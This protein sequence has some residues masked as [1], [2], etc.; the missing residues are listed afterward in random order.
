M[1]VESRELNQSLLSTI[2]T[3]A[4]NFDTTVDGM[5]KLKTAGVSDSV[6]QAMRDVQN[7]AQAVAT[8]APNI[9]SPTGPSAA[10]RYIC[11][12]NNSWYL[13]LRFDN[14]FL[15]K[16]R[17]EINGS[18]DVSGDMVTLRFTT[19]QT[20]NLTLQGERLIDRAG[21]LARTGRLP[22]PAGSAWVKPAEPEPTSASAQVAN[23]SVR[24]RHSGFGLPQTLLGG[25]LGVDYS[26]PC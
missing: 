26:A 23:F 12:L 22:D 15:L 1:V 19:G 3:S 5:V 18:Y 20:S 21:N 13:D 17:V 4:C 14:T 11:Q 2:K 7:E 24:H 6:I 8:A 9:E 10:G 16:R 25:G